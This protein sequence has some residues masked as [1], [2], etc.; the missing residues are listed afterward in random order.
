MISN[1]HRG[2]LYAILAGF[3]YGFVGYFGV[4]AVRSS[5]SVSNMLFWRF[6]IASGAI[7]LVLV[8]QRNQPPLSQK[9]LCITF[10]NGVLF[11][12]VSTL[13]YFFACPYI[14]SGLSMVIFFTYPAIVM[15]LNHFFYGQSIPIIYYFSIIIIGCGMPLFIDTNEI[16]FDM[17]GIIL[18]ILSALLYAGYLISCKK[19]STFSPIISTLMVCLGCMCTSLILALATHTLF[20]PSTLSVWL[21][22]LGIGILCTAAPILLLLHGLNYISAEKT[23]ILSVLEPIFV[24]I[25]GVTLLGEPMKLRYIIGVCIVLTGALLTLLSQTPQLKQPWKRKK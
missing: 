19:I 17:L 11:Y 1:E 14:G 21:D 5:L 22:L 15:V 16:E 13:L 20:I 18:S 6:L 3:L 4:S 23:A 8:F 7:V 24:L 25:F 9:D 12:G 2:S 10:I